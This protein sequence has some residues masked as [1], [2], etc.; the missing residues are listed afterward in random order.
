MNP[1]AQLHR[2]HGFGFTGYQL[3]LSDG[4]G[5]AERPP[6]AAAWLSSA[7]SDADVVVIENAVASAWRGRVLR[8]KVPVDTRMDLWRLMAHANVCVDLAPG[9]HIAR[10]CIEAQRFA[11]PIIV[12]ASSGAG[13]VHAQAGGGATFSDEHDLLEA[14]A[15]FESATRRATAKAYADAHY[16]DPVALVRRI[17]DL[18]AQPGAQRSPDA[19]IH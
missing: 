8:G 14:A 9:P 4:S 16:G 1:L 10:E 13:A 6:A 18:L 19:A 17:A 11:T 5:S 12:P 15:T 3:V 2:H 7:F